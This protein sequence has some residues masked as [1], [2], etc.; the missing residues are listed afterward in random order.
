MRLLHRWP[1]EAV[2]RR[3]GA[4]MQ[5]VGIDCCVEQ[6]DDGAWELWI[7]PEDQRKRAERELAAFLAAPDDPRFD[8]PGRLARHLDREEKIRP[9]EP[10]QRSIVRPVQ[11]APGPVTLGL[12]GIA[13]AVTA[14]C[15]IGGDQLGVQLCDNARRTGMLTFTQLIPHA[16]W[17]AATGLEAILHGQVWRLLTP[18]FLHFS[19]LHILF[20][21]WWLHTLGASVEARGGRARLIAMVVILG[22]ASNTGQYLWMRYVEHQVGLFGGFSGVVYG[23]LA[24][25]WLRGRREPHCGIAVPPGTMAFMMVWFALGWFGLIGPIANMAHTVGLVGGCL[26]GLADATLALRRRS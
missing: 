25:V 7:I 17:Q 18:I 8:A 16:N 9:E 21:L 1:H 24:Y 5:N 13:I 4:H 15:S 12:I 10:L 3:C 2:C 20:N 19:I 23:L 26:W 6:A 14:F 22:V 11:Y